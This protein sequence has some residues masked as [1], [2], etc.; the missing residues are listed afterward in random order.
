MFMLNSRSSISL[1]HKKLTASAANCKDLKKF[2]LKAI[3]YGQ[4]DIDQ[5]KQRHWKKIIAMSFSL[6]F[7]FQQMFFGFES[8]Y[9]SRVLRKPK[10]KFYKANKTMFLDQILKMLILLKTEMLLNNY[11][12][13]INLL[14]L[15]VI[16]TSNK[17]LLNI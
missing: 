9:K 7:I 17:T 12:Q 15:K 1:D 8:L 3:S 5:S 13:L 10:C 6:I 16:L 2:I 4:Q 11:S 14:C